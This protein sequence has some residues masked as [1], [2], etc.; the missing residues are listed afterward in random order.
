MLEGTTLANEYVKVMLQDNEPVNLA[1][2]DDG[3]KSNKNSVSSKL[4]GVYSLEGLKEEEFSLRIWMDED[5]PLVED[6]M[7]KAMYSKIVIN[8]S[9]GNGVDLIPGSNEVA[10]P[11]LYAGLIPITYDEENNIL[12]ADTSTEWYDYDKHEWANAILIDQ[13][14]AAIKN[15]Y[16]DNDGTFISGTKVDINDVLQMYVWI[17]RYR[18]QLFNVDGNQTTAQMINIEFENSS[19]LKITGEVSFPKIKQFAMMK[20]S[21]IIEYLGK[22]FLKKLK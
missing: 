22:L 3:L 12:V 19:K 6:A 5:T 13:S 17:P 16:I 8:A 15:K 1:T 21:F 9:L 18:Y 11:E 14:N 4:L 20:I 2:L 7:N 10:T